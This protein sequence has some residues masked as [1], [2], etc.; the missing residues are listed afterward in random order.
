MSWNSHLQEALQARAH[1]GSYRR[2]PVRQAACAQPYIELNGKRYQNFAGNDYLGLSGD[3]EIIKAWQQA[4]AQYGA[5]SGG[6]GHVSGHT[7]VHEALEQDLSVWLGYE[8]AL[9]FSSGYAANQAVLLGLLGKDDV[10]LADKLCHASMQ[11]AAMLGAAQYRR[12]PHQQ[13]DTLAGWLPAYAGRRV[14]VA[15]E[16]VFSMDGDSAD[17]C[18]L[19]ALCRQHGAWLVLDDAHGIGILGEHGAGSASVAGVQPDILIITFGKAVGL[20]GAAILC[21]ETVAEYLTQYARHLIYSTTMPPAQAAA[22]Q[23]AFRRVRE[24]DDLRARLQNNIRYFQV[25]LQQ[26]GLAGKL[27]P[28]RTPIQPF[29]CGSNAAALHCAETLRGQGVYA[30]AIRPPTVPAGQARLRI[31][32]SAAH[33]PT[34]IDALIQGLCH[35]V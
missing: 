12:F 14:L 3:T 33:E 17:V 7:D 31:T 25:A 10:L 20:M 4:L 34:H 16:G 8:R 11:E 35:A 9:L 30:P 27:L 22:L 15:S 32:L 23:T 2:R 29:I 5:G 26:Q 18:R 1:G 19:H 13:Y 21:S 24:A 28:S 6:S